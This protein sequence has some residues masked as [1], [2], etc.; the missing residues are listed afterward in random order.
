MPNDAKLGLVLGVGLVIA[1][2]VI[3]FHKELSGARQ[4]GEQPPAGVVNPPAPPPPA[5]GRVQGYPTAARTTSDERDTQARRHTVEDGDTL[6]SLAERYYSDPA[7]FLDLYQHNRDVLQ[8]P[9]RLEVGTVLVIP[10]LTA[11]EPGASAPG[12]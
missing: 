11:S 4:T 1:V 12:D 3:F 10:D 6:F 5:G 2:A 7:R 8:R 9:D